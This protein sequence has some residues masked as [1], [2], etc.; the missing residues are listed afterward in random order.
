MKPFCCHKVLQKV[1]P[2]PRRNLE[3][4]FA[5]QHDR[6]AWVLPMDEARLVIAACLHSVPNTQVKKGK[7]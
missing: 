2:D 5:A 6:I 4:D 7:K 1:G 3:R